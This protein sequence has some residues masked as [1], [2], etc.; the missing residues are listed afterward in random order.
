MAYTN[1]RK[2]NVVNNT[3]YI[4]HGELRPCRLRCLVTAGPLKLNVKKYTYMQ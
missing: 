1:R 4:G 2:H 3:Q